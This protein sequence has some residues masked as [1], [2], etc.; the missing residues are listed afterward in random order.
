MEKPEMSRTLANSLTIQIM[1]KNVFI[2]SYSSNFKGTSLTSK[3]FNSD[4][5]QNKSNQSK[6]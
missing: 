3:D 5:T 4:G 6:E 1:T 2:N